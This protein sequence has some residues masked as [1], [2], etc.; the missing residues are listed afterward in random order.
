[1]VA[2]YAL[3]A[4]AFGLFGCL[5]EGAVDG[6]SSVPDLDPDLAPSAYLVSADQC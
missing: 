2:R 6:S 1:M 4:L 3:L 5:D